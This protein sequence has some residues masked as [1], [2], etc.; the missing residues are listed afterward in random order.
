[1]IVLAIIGIGLI[2]V[3]SEDKKGDKGN[4]AVPS[5]TSSTAIQ[6]DLNT[7]AANQTQ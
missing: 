1:L 4:N 2:S 6:T 5:Q 3:S 7:I